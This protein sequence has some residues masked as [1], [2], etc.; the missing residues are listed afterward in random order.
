MLKNIIWICLILLVCKGSAVSAHGVNLF[1]EREGLKLQGE[2]YFSGGRPVKNAKIEVFGKRGQLVATTQTDAEGRFA[3]RLMR[4]EELKGV[5]HAGQGHQGH[6]T[7]PVEQGDFAAL[8]AK[9]TSASSTTDTPSASQDGK[10][11]RRD[12]PQKGISPFMVFVGLMLILGI[13]YVL[14]RWKQKHAS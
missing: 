14:H 6:C 10:K 12:R 4:L 13:F 11:G 2:G 8:Q 5:L 3:I 7:V 1:C 9:G